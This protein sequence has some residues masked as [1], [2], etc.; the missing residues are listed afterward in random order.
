MI[1]GAAT[2][3]MLWAGQAFAQASSG[4]AAPRPAASPTWDSQRLETAIQKAC[5]YL[6]KSLDKEGK[7]SAEPKPDDIRYG[8]RTALAVYALLSAEVGQKDPDVRRAVDWLVKQKL[9]GTYAVSLRACALSLMVQ[10]AKEDTLVKALEADLDWLLKACGKDGCYT[11]TPLDGKPSELYDNSNSQM[12][13]LGVWMASRALPWKK[14]PPEFWQKVER[15]WQSQQQVDGGWG[16]LIPRGQMTARP[17]GS[18]TAAGLA[19][20]FICFDYL[21]RDQFVRCAPEETY[22]PVEQA[23]GWLG[24]HFDITDNPGKPSERYFYWLYCLERVGMASGQKYI[25]G[26]DWYASGIA[27]L[28]AE[29]RGKS[30]GPHAQRDDGSWGSD[31]ADTAFA[32]MFALRG[33]HPVLLNKL[34]YGGKWN[35]RPRDAAN[36]TAWMSHAFERHFTWQAVRSDAPAADIQDAP[37]L[38]ISGAGACEPGDKELQMLRDFVH[39][40]GT[41]ISESAGN[42]ADF[43]LDMQRMYRK[44]FPQYKLVRLS[45]EHPVY[46]AQ[47]KLD[48]NIGLLGVSNGIRTLAVHSPKELSLGLQLEPTA[49]YLASYETMANV[50]IVLTDRANIP[51]RGSTLWPKAAAFK[52]K[53]AIS[54][55]RVKFDGNHDPEPMAWQR[56]VLLAGNRHGI[57]VDVQADVEMARLDAKKNAVAAMTGTGE[58]ALTKEQAAGLR[59]F[60]D[61]GGL[62]MIDCAGGDEAFGKSVRQHVLPLVEETSPGLL[63]DDH[64][65]YGKFVPLKIRYKGDASTSADDRK[66]KPGRLIGVKKDGRVKI[67]FSEDDLTAGMLGCPAYGVK[68]YT[69]ETSISLMLNILLYAQKNAQAP[70]ASTAPAGR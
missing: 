33:R 60:L 14:V 30:C 26:H 12:A 37:I 68:G 29:D 59:K 20:M 9:T 38:Y 22:K 25:G 19:T 32:L 39:R 7:C 11:Y 64:D 24:K 58:F 50:C 61:D 54:V 48:P 21:H 10:Q 65:V 31:A 13:V 70:A 43:T 1:A 67:I 62:L 4:A 44:L 27:E 41:I 51:P 28:L 52:P 46:S 18:M 3:V 16:Y 36:F 23:A 47:F 40:G 42:N 56:L 45:R 69:S 8:G 66:P 34:N 55:A 57:K 6:R 63:P 5:T 49:T 2:A 17:Y 53:P 35:S 15:H